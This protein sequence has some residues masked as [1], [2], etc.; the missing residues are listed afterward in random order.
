MTP[1]P[2][3]ICKGRCCRDEFGYRIAHMGAEFYEHVCD[4]CFN[5]DKYVPPLTYEQGIAEGERRATAAVV[6]WLREHWSEVLEQTPQQTARL[7]ERGEH[8][9][10][11][12]P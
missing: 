5:G 10:E 6:A 11:G 3:P 8:R 7:I 4:D 1:E 9:R 12:K 2:C